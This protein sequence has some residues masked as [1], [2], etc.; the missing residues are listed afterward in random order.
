[1][2]DDKS[3]IK[4]TDILDKKVEETSIIKDEIN[5]AIF[6]SNKDSIILYRIGKDG[7]I[8]NFIEAN[9][10]AIKLFGYTKN[11]L[12]SLNVKDIESI[13]DKKL[14]SR[15]EKIQTTGSINFK[16]VVKT[17]NGNKR[18]VE[19]ENIFLN[20]FDEPAILSIIRDVTERKQMENNIKK[21][22]ESLTTILEAIP[23][24]LF[25]VGFDGRIYHYQSHRDDFLAVSPSEFMGK[26]FQDILP[27]DAAKVCF[28]AIN[29]AN[30]KGWSYGKQYSLDLKKGIFWFE[31][32][33]SPIENGL[34]KDKHFILLARDITT[35]KKSEQALQKSQEK[36][37]GVFDLAN[38][39]IIL[40]DLRGKYLLFNNWLMEVLG[41]TRAEMNKLGRADITHPDDLEK[42]NMLFN[43]IIEGKIDRYQLEKRFI[44]KDKSFFWGEISTSAI[45]DRNN[46][47]VNTIGIIT[48]I[49]ER[50]LNEEKL[51][52]S[53]SRLLD[54]QKVAKVGSWE[55]D[56]TFKNVVWSTEIYRIFGLNPEKTALTLELFMSFVHPDDQKIIESKFIHS[57]KTNTINSVEHRI[58]TPDGSLKYVEQ[59]WKIVIDNK[60]N[61]IRAEGT[62]QDITERKKVEKVQEDSLNLIRKITSRVPGVVYQYLLRPDGSSCFPYA[63]DGIKQIYDVYPDDVKEDASKVFAN[64]HPEDLETVS[65]SIQESAKNLTLWNKEY[66]VK[67]KNGTILFV[68]GN[69]IPQKEED[70]SVVWHGYIT[71]ITD[72]KISE[73]KLRENQEFLKQTQIIAK[74]GS[75]SLDFK[76]G[77][78]TSNS[79]L[80]TVFGIDKNFDWTIEGWKSLIH[81]EWKQTIENHLKNEVIGKKNSFNKE[82]K[83]IKAD[84]KQERWVH[85]LGEIIYNEKKEPLQLIGTIQD[86]T[87]EKIYEEKLRESEEKYRGLVEGSPDGIVLYSDEKIVYIN[88]E[89]LRMIGAKN[90][91][92]IIGKPI[93]Q[94]IHPESKNSIIKRMKEVVMDNNASATVEEK[95][96]DLNGNS[97]D[98]EIKA[99]PTIY[100]HKAAVQVIVHDI[101]ERKQTQEKIRQLSRAV[102]QSP[103]TIVITNTKGEIEYANPKFVETTGYSLDEVIG[104]N[105][106]VLK[107]GYTSP[108]EYK[109]LWKTLAAGKEWHGEFH[110]MKK[111]GDLYWESASISPIV[112]AQ[113]QITHF[114]AIKEDITS[115][116]KTD[117]ELIKA[118]NKAEESDRLKLAFLANMSHEIRTPMNGILGFTELLKEPKLTGEE[119]QEYI[120]I[121]E[122]SGKRMLNIINDIINISKVESGQIEI[123]LS[124]TN[125]NEQIGYLNTFFKPETKQKGIK[126]LVK[127]QLSNQNCIVLTDKEKIY[128][129]LT[130]LVKNAI[131]F[132][133]TGSIEFG[134]VKKDKFLEFFVKD[135]GLGISLSQQKMIFERF[136]QANETMTRT[137]EGSGLGLAISKAYV[138]M[139][140]GKI[141]VES[142]IGIGSTF[143]FTIP[144]KDGFEL[145]KKNKV[146]KEK[147]KNKEENKVKNLKILI[148]EDD[149]ISKLLITIAVKPYSKD[150]L[151]VSTGIEAVETCR[152]NPDID[153]VMMDINMPEMGGYEA[154]KLIREFN[155]NLIIIAQTANGMESDR[156]N[157]IAAGCTDYISKPVNITSLSD[158]IKKYF[159]KKKRN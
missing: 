147:T 43:Q 27:N 76:S 92:E 71:D 38:S 81:P 107:S 60:G 41:Y 58:I 127:E 8:S 130:N 13:S 80:E 65:E 111:N 10:A 30:E 70:G 9:P 113:G 62:C 26:L 34:D 1:M 141:W 57:I 11:E 143:Y 78:W 97:I 48:D 74:I 131:K 75:Y 2:K 155:E 133:N 82:Y 59:R 79:I 109:E 137:H 50:K 35:R 91:S 23:D 86:V 121:I 108:E 90:R 110:N 146:K 106:R 140:G 67:H 132:T 4:P 12:L 154:T 98:V 105:P 55:T 104:Q 72:R 96:V 93:L 157:A 159:R 158:L 152:S 119:Q 139:L 54:A 6:E 101:T 116:K 118:K 87:E 123:K 18:N 31:L 126:L 144:Y 47:T 32:S 114:I 29:E 56:L 153:L 94:F 51:K 148:V 84:N 16:T 19:I 24:L 44:R 142:K 117:I 5:Q 64:I 39:G 28:E 17:K 129:I 145:E 89:G 40:T 22:N 156:D 102:E 53:E 52:I 103:V 136:R 125:I 20:N 115:R 122:K 45:K 68:L 77:K 138:E 42:S 46:K 149:A 21:A 14:E 88:D 100:D 95:F 63:S 85:G 134:C 25:E 124:E 135:S 37:R 61:A 7:K 151:K 112:N 66:R 69:S 15:I 36:L 150:I 3:K 49:T 99:I 128:A 33:V 83:I 120:E 73:E